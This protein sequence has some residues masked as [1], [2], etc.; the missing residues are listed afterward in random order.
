MPI[1]GLIC[2]FLILHF[3][4]SN[5]IQHL[6]IVIG[7]LCYLSFEM[8]VPLFCPFIV[9]L[10]SFIIDFRGSNIF[11]IIQLCQLYLL[12]ISFLILRLL[13][14]YFKVSISM[15]LNL[16]CFSLKLW[17]LFLCFC[18]FLIFLWNPSL[19]WSHENFHGFLSIS[20][21]FLSLLSCWPI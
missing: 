11:L 17:V 7:H 1:I 15:W 21:V 20:K 5:K 19:P 3:L 16:L 9:S 18:F 10:L 4:I 14:V 2:W 6:L 8:C 13:C 12:Q